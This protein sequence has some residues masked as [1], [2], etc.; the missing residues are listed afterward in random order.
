M[1]AKAKET[2][3]RIGLAAL[4]GA[5]MT[6]A[7]PALAF[8]AEE[9]SSGGLS[10]ILPD[11]AEFIPMLVI[12]I[13]LWIVLAKFGWPKFEAML[14]KREMTIK[15]SLEKSEQARVESE[16][17][18]EEYK[19]QLEDAKA[20]AAQIVADAK[21][22]GEAVKADITDKAQ[23]EATAMIEK[24]HN[25]IEAEKKAAISELQGSV[26]DLS[27]S[28][29]SRLIGEDLNDT[30]HRKIIEAGGQDAVLEVRDQAER[31]LR[32]AR[33]NMDLSDALEDSSYTPEQR[34]QLVRNLFA[35]SNPVLVDV[36][37]VMAEREDFAL[38][39]RV[40]ASYGEQL[41]RKLNVTVVD[42]TTVVELDDHLRE[43]I[44]KK[45]EAD[46]GTNVVLREHI[47]KSLLGGILMS[48]NGKRIDAS[49]LSQL[50]S[51]RNVLKL[52]TDGGEC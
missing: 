9:E 42:V 11:M 20:Q 19:R 49:V 4:A 15:D 39:S 46:L 24:A 36:L 10:A 29:A 52:S 27:V 26:A 51:A 48:A 30:E 47:D 2:S 8:A 43:V 3:A 6:F 17:V 23:S 45:A 44:T 28:V 33:S 22:T 50:E 37:A 13:L 40:W 31:I 18:L 35:S 1:K 14:E 21:K 25:A 32:I 5:G 7:F 38:L 16:R 12:F 34:G 41:E